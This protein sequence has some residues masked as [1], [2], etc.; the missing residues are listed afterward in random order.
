MKLQRDWITPVTI[1]AFGVLAVTGVLMFFHLDSGL[2]KAVH[3]WLSWLLVGAV[4]LH[5]VVNWGAFRR[6]L[7]ARRGRAVVG[8]FALLLGLSFAPLGKTS[9][10]PPFAVPVQALAAA[11]LPVLAQ[12]GRVPVEEMRARLQRAGLTPA[13]DT[14]SVGSLVGPDRKRQLRVLA[15]VLEPVAR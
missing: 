10:G 11:P 9:G 7:T 14:D 3:E 1:G 2:N 15:K 6:H 8:V 4:A 5:A 12:V 13:S